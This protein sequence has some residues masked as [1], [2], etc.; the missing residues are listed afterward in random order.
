MPISYDEIF[1]KSLIFSHVLLI[2]AK[3]Y[4]R[5]ALHFTLME[6]SQG[7]NHPLAPWKTADPADGTPS[8]VPNFSCN[9]CCRGN[10][11]LYGG[12]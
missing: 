7:N 6:R 8:V 2:Y 3:R 12:Y 10:L 5:N 11:E 4:V 9:P 1:Y